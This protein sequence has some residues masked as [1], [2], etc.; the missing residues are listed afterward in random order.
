MRSWTVS[1]SFR[2]FVLEQL[3]ELGAVSARSMFGGVGLYH[4]DVFFGIIAAD[5]LYLKV[6][7]RSRADYE[8]LGMRAFSP[9]PERSGS[10][11]YYE[12]PLAVLESPIE[13][14]VWARRA[15]AA[16]SDAG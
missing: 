3:E 7:A 2:A 14:A 5:I 10:M 12:V 6:D 13:L 8:A 9:Y 15:V 11:Q 1:D 4:E 16:A